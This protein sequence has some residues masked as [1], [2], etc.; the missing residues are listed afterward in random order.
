M[1]HQ[2]RTETTGPDPP[3]V[4]GVTDDSDSL[5]MFP[6]ETP[7]GHAHRV[8][9]R[10]PQVRVPSDN[11]GS[12]G[13]RGDHE[14]LGTLA[15]RLEGQYERLAKGL[16]ESDTRSTAAL[17]TL[18]NVERQ[19]A[20]LAGELANG[21]G[22]VRGE[23]E[24]L[25]TVAARLEGQ[26]ER[27]A[28]GL[29][30][31]DTRSASALDSLRNAERQAAE[32]TAAL[33]RLGT[34]TRALLDAKPVLLQTDR[35]LEAE[36][37][38]VP[39]LS[40]PNV[41]ET[42]ERRQ[43]GVTGIANLCMQWVAGIADRR[44]QWWVTAIANRR[45]QRWVTGISN[46]RIPAMGLV[47]LV[48]VTLAIASSLMRLNHIREAPVVASPAVAGNPTNNP[49]PPT[50][51]CR[52]EQDVKIPDPPDAKKSTESD[53]SIAIIQ[54]ARQAGRDGR[55]GPE[56]QGTESDESVAIIHAALCESTARA[57]ICWDSRGALNSCRR[58]RVGG[59]AFSRHYA[60]PAHG[61]SCT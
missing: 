29:S 49:E 38:Q 32:L 17:D 53:S 9:R 42:R 40:A 6:S 57:R 26:Y 10:P 37:P 45:M 60:T 46:R 11:H 12:V 35:A 47:A 44:M 18:R 5:S 14:Q 22:G 13:A 19:V 27:L 59:W 43:W 8:G 56:S 31:A 24:Q 16:S 7:D 51:A 61:A 39:T 2:A 54:P 30:E 1:A 48:L 3:P 34:Q 23:L 50:S 21:S 36:T 55:V 25:R 4:S 41:A 58:H 15:A 33:N 20:A 52:S 28:K